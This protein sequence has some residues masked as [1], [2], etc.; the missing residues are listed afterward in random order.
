M[1]LKYGVEV[2]NYAIESIFKKITNQIYKLLPM[3][4]ENG[5][6]KK[7][8]ETIMEELAG[9][10][11]MLGKQAAVFASLLFTLEGLFSL[12]QEDDFQLHRRTIFECLSICG[13]LKEGL[14]C[15]D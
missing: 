15:Q 4:E 14:V 6:W 9:M 2:D 10:D 7:P 8:L 13:S 12:V 3:R 1:V 11:R 5:D